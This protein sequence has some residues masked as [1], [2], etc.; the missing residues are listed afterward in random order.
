MDKNR[1]IYQLRMK[2]KSSKEVGEIFNM[3]RQGVEYIIKKHFSPIKR[4][5][6]GKHGNCK[7]CTKTFYTYPS[8]NDRKNNQEFCSNECR[9]SFRR[10][11]TEN[12]LFKMTVEERREFYRL[13]IK[14]YYKTVNGNKIIRNHLN[15]NKDKTKDSAR[16]ILNEAVRTS[17]VIKPKTCSVCKK[18][19]IRICG[20]HSDYS[21]PL[22]VKWVCYPCHYKIHHV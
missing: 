19:N 20:H 4:K 5:L 13:K 11:N 6:K 15:K 22:K 18:Q 9:N 17:K 12:K 21:K 3:S 14:R 1:Q 7:N 8:Y 2:G 10:K 16:I